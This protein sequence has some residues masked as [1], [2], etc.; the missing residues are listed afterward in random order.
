MRN[1]KKYSIV[2]RFR[3]LFP[4]QLGRLAM[5]G[6]RAGGDLSHVDS[7]RSSLNEQ[8]MGSANWVT[9]LQAE[10]SE[11]SRSNH[12]NAVAARK[13]KRRHKEMRELERAGLRDPWKFTCHGPLREGILTVNAKWFGGAGGRNWNPGQVRAFRER[14]IS[15]LTKYFGDSCVYARIDCDEDALHFHFVI[16][17]WN[18]KISANRGEQKLL[19]PSCHP[20]IASYEYAQDV[21]GEFFA[22]LGLVRGQRRAEQTR[23]A[24]K[25]GLPKPK[26]AYH[27]PPQVWRAKQLHASMMEAARQELEEEALDKK[28]KSLEEREDALSG[29]EQRAQALQIGLQAIACG[30]LV[31]R[32]AKDDLPERLAFSK[33]A[34][35]DVM[36][37]SN[38]RDKIK[39]AYS[40]LLAN[41][42]VVHIAIQK[43]SAEKQAALELLYDDQIKLSDQLEARSAELL[44]DAKRLEEECQRV[45][46]IPSRLLPEII[47]KYSLGN[48]AKRKVRR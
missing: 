36:Q 22:D 11:A 48:H 24:K 2:L 23:A 46:S 19:Q 26:H 16:A 42:R 40:T 6:A 38:L 13:A 4:S 32:A 18:I 17:A 7:T 29:Q 28:A 43:A 44:R 21:A 35:K 20:L 33:I 31:W 45:H 41:A 3:G 9:E 47:T 30:Q 27:V 1:S 25:L 37:R 8:V 12:G 10:I 5:H 39:P 34:P 15:F 14:G